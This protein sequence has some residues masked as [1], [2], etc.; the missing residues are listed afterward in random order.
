MTL[1]R[2]GDGGG[3][4]GEGD[5]RAGGDVRGIVDYITDEKMGW[6]WLD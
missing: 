3:V 4:E 5:G 2:G 1:V 6:R